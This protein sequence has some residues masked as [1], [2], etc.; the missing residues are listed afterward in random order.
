[1]R[2]NFWLAPCALITCV[3]VLAQSTHML[4]PEGSKDIFVSLAAVSTPVTEGSRARE[5]NV[6]PLISAQWANGVFVNMNTVG[7]HLSERSDMEYGPLFT[8]MTS[9]VG[10]NTGTDRQSKSRF[11][12]EIGGFINYRI[13]HGMGISTRLMYGGSSDHRGLRWNAGAYLWT[14]LS[15]HHSVGIQSSFTLANSSSLQADFSTRE[16]QAKGGMRDADVS[17]RWRWELNHT[18]T[19]NTWIE[20]QRFLGGAGRSPRLERKSGTTA[21]AMVT[22]QF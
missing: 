19:L 8:P 4:M 21:A 20:E 7:M 3:P 16:Y 15:A 12:P 14:P 13:A 5:I 1:M 2:A 6:V 11:T 18:T 10:G 17:L 9:R 22:W